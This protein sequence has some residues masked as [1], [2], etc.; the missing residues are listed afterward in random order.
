V[1]LVWLAQG[2]AHGGGERVELPLLLI[3]IGIGIPWGLMDALAVSVVAP[4]RVGMA[5]GIFNTVRVSADG[6]AI[7]IIGVL[8]ATWIQSG[9]APHATAFA[10][11]AGVEAA[12][13][14]AL[15]DL[16]AA[17][18]LLPGLEAKLLASYTA[19]FGSVLHVLAGLATVTACVV[20]VMLRGDATGA[21][22]RLA[23]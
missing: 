10:P 20:L 18:H 2:F 23:R 7:A 13:R 3:G 1:G 15:G 9:L 22:A 19:A 14:L 16:R 8:L 17:A 11:D 5:T 4:H 12:G 21:S 6:I